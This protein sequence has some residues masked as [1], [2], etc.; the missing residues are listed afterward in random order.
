MLRIRLSTVALVLATSAH[1]QPRDMTWQ[2]LDGDTLNLNGR[3]MS[4]HGVS[5][6]PTS[7]AAGL[8]AKRLANTFLRGGVVVC[9]TSLERNGRE[10]VDCAKRGNNGLSLS[11][12]L[13]FKTLCTPRRNQNCLTPNIDA[14]PTYAPPPRRAEDA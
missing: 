4:I 7:L 9:V 13:V 14:M 12:M 10:D 11:Q 8:R 3:I 2:A 6:P 5:C 1:G